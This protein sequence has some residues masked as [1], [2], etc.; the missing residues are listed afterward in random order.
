VSGLPRL[1]VF[2]PL[3]PARTGVAD[4]AQLLLPHLAA[5]WDVVV[6]VPD[7][8]PR[9]VGVPEGVT[10]LRQ[11]AWRWYP[12]LH[13]VDRVLY[14][15]GNSVQHLGVPDLVARTGGVVLAH[16]VRMTALQCLRAARHAE[17]HWLSTLVSSHY[18][19]HLGAELHAL[20]Q[21]APV[22]ESF[23]EARA[24]LEAANTYLLAEAVSGA[25]AVAVH[26][27]FAARLASIELHRLGI[28]VEVVPFGHPDP[29]PLPGPRDPATIATFG[30]VAIEKAPELLISA[31]VDVAKAVPDARLRFVGPEAGPEVMAS[32]RRQ[33]RYLGVDEQVEFAGGLD[34]AG[35]RH[36]L[37]TATVAA[38]LRRSVNGE[39]SG[40]VA[41][42]LGTG[43]PTVATALG[44][45]AGLP[46]DVVVK[47]RH[48][49][50]PRSLAWQLSS[51]LGDAPRRDE[52]ARR[53]RR[54]AAAHSFAVAAEELSVLLERSPVPRL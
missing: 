14:Q 13:T 43:T 44:S 10:V 48:D 18:G 39:S 19:R 37:A 24:L 21:R 38:Q 46:D 47:V 35:W 28:P 51:L 11:G 33:A 29:S 6:F 50:D 25:D 27:G 31:M 12:E 41:D 40:A 54:Y 22:A 42:C 34:D 32:L 17:R 2:T 23:A 53:A 26:S 3:P 5:R 4:Y 8:A 7:D 36:A 15:L 45:F 16:E 52:L 1:A 30:R 20:E 9:P 49:V